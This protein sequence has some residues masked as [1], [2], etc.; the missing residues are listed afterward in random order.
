MP[1]QSQLISKAQIEH[2]FTPISLQDYMTLYLHLNPATDP[3]DLRIRLELAAAA[4]EQQFRCSC[5][6]EIWI[7][8][9]AEHGLACFTCITGEAYPDSD[10]EIDYQFDT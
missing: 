5:G 4:K 9:S 6:S 2:P 7:I 8:G 10:Y 3:E 1:D